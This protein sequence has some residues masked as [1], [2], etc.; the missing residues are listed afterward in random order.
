[1]LR[2]VTG[3]G[4]I[5]TTH[6]VKDACSPVFRFGIATSACIRN[7]A[8]DLRDALPPVPTRHLAA[9]GEPAKVCWSS[10]FD[11]SGWLF[12]CLFCSKALGGKLPRLECSRTLL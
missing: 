5:E 2:R 9:I 12:D 7:P 3:G 11:Y 8:A 1:M 6:R 4:A 10:F